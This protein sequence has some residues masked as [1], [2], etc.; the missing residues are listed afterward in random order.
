[1]KYIVCNSENAVFNR[2]YDELEKFIEPGAVFSFSEQILGTQFSKRIIDEHNNGKYNYNHIIF[3][4]QKE[5]CNI[6]IEEDNSIYRVMRKNFYKPLGVD[7]KNIFYPEYNSEEDVD[8][9]NTILE[10]N[11]ID[12]VLLILDNQGNILN[13]K[14]VQDENR[15][16]HIYKISEL[17]KLTLEENFNLK[18]VENIITVGYDDIV[19]ARN[20]FL[21][22]LGSDKRKY[23]ENIFEADDNSDEVISLLKN[24]RNLTIFVDKEAGYK[25]EEEVNKLIKE[26]ARKKEIEE[27][28]KLEET[29]GVE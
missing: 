24:N 22:A 10:E 14:K 18:N 2:V 28:R 13:Y 3:L 17:E 6:D 29:L 9:Y 19:S 23:V 5:I 4:G 11:P 21:V 26:K 25:S 20:I 27:L 1:M 15:K 7:Y 8:K 16:T 12:V